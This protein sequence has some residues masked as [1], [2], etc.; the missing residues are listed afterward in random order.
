[1]RSL[2]VA[3]PMAL[4]VPAIIS[5]AGEREAIR[6]LEFEDRRLPARHPRCDMHRLDGGNRRHA[7]IGTPSEE[8]YDRRATRSALMRS[9]GSRSRDFP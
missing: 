8:L 6:F 1:M 9:S 4:V 3:E 7:G 5:A 2:V